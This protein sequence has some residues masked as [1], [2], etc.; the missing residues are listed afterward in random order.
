M[1]GK[2]DNPNTHRLPVLAY[3]SHIFLRDAFL[4]GCS[5]FCKD[6][7]S[8]DELEA[9]LEKMMSAISRNYEFP[10]GRIGFSGNDVF[11][12]DRR[13]PLTYQEAR[14]LRMLVEQRGSVVPRE[15]LFYAIWGNRGSETS[16]V[17]DVHVASIRK[18]IHSILE[19]KED[20]KIISPVRNIGYII[21]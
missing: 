10:W 9:R 21:E 6:P 20:V 1:I 13:I 11:V 7:W 5:D 16:R 8:L 14:V 2:I 18:K 17:V 12:A 3:G 4:S 15:A 19:S